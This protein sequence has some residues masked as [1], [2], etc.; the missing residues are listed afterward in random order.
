[1]A[2]EPP[3]GARHRSQCPGDLKSRLV[4]EVHS[5][6]RRV[7]EAELDRLARRVPT[8]GRSDLDIIDVALEQLSESL[9]LA[10]LRNA[11]QDTVPLLRSLL[12]TPRKEP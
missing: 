1:M 9:I 4:A 11:S 5:H 8:L 7:I 3:L 6:N 12:G 10:G 2:T